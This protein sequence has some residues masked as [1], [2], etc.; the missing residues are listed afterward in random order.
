VI[1]FTA[2]FTL[3]DGNFNSD[4]ILSIFVGNV[5]FVAMFVAVDPPTIP[6]FNRGRI[7]YGIGLGLFT[8]LI[9]LYSAFPEG[10][11]FAVI[12]MNAVGPLFDNEAGDLDE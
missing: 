3:L 7:L 2:L 10:A 5:L 1:G 4:F 8:V 12:I 11:L 6:L 9:R